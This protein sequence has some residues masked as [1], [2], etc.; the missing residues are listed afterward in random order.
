MGYY[1][2]MTIQGEEPEEFWTV[3]NP[4]ASLP[5]CDACSEALLLDKKAKKWQCPKCS[6]EDRYHFPITPWRQYTDHQHILN[7]VQTIN[8]P[9]DPQQR[10]VFQCAICH[11]QFAR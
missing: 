8:I 6:R 1:T 5:E 3:L 4:R 11:E 2:R 10:T 9:N 7:P